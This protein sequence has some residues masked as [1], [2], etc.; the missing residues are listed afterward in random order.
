MSAGYTLVNVNL[1]GF[2]NSGG[3]ASIMSAHQ[4]KC[5]REA[6]AWAGAQDWSTGAVGLCGVSFLCIS[7]YLAAA[8]PEGETLPDALKCIVPWEGVSDLYRDLA[9]RGGVADVGFLNFWWL[10]EVKESLNLGLEEYLSIEE[11]IPVDVLKTHPFYDEYWKA[12]APRVENITVPMLVCASF[13]DHEL[14]T[15]GSFRAYEKSSSEQKWLYTH[16]SGKWTEFYKQETSDL[17]KSFMDRFLKGEQTDFPDKPSVR[18][19]VRKDRNTIHDIRWENTWPIENTSYVAL[20]L[21]EN[22]LSLEPKE[23]P[24]FQSYDG[25]EG[26]TEFTYIF[27]Q[28]TEIS[29]YIKL[30]VWVE[31]K[32]AEDMALCC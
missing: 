15:F 8:V 31:A 28:D 25:K 3:S 1:P 5:Y 14:H 30:K 7:Q 2:A 10:T 22:T 21:A 23:S 18:L 6:I 17:I 16:R 26:R 24:A 12:K 20:H 13:S 19:E 4:C 27:P 11:A 29:G 32:G 9:C